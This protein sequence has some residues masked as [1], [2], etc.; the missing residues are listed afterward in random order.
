MKFHG[1]DLSGLHKEVP[2]EILPKELG[3]VYR[4][5]QQTDNWK[6]S[7]KL[8]YLQWD[9]GVQQWGDCQCC[10]E[11]GG[12]LPGTNQ[13]RI[14]IVG[15]LHASTSWLSPC[16]VSLCLDTKI[17]QTHAKNWTNI[18]LQQWKYLF[19]PSQLYSSS[20]SHISLDMDT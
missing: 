19:V 9:S 17:T 20:T 3:L 14:D 6:V 7:F 18:R 16:S 5:F 8:I 1:F 15:C 12:S 11:E 10:Q 4:Y 2:I 13:D